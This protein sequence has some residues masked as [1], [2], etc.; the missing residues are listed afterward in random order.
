MDKRGA[1]PQG[2]DGDASSRCARGKPITG[3][4]RRIELAEKLADQAAAAESAGDHK[5]AA[6]LYRKAIDALA[7]SAGAV[8]AAAND[9]RGC[10]TSLGSDS[11]STTN[12]DDGPDRD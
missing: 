4:R 6:D 2:S 9:A 8:L 12:R 7:L 1:A 10:E 3:V 5:A 11:S